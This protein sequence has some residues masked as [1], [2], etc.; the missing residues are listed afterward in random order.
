MP[1]I[2]RV[3]MFGSA[4]RY[5]IANHPDISDFDPQMDTSHL[6]SFDANNLYGHSL[7]QF[8]PVSDF[9]WLTRDEIDALDISTH[10]KRDPLGYYLEVDLTY[11]QTLHDLHNDFPLAPEKI[12]L[13]T[14]GL[15]P[16]TIGLMEKLK[17]K[18]ICT[19]LMSTLTDKRRYILHYE[20]LKL[21]LCLGLQ[22]TCIHRCI[23]FRQKDFIK[24]YIA[25][26][27]RS[28]KEA[29]N[30]FEVFQFKL[31]NNSIY[32]RC[33]YNIFRQVNV[34]LVSDQKKFQRLA[35][36]PTFA[37]TFS[38]NERLVNL[39]M[40]PAVIVCNKPVFIGTSV[41]D[42]SKCHMY[43]F[44]YDHLMTMYSNRGLRL[45][46]TDTDSFHIQIMNCPDVYRDILKYEQFF[47]CS[48]YP[49][50]HFLHSTWHKRVLGLMKMR[51]QGML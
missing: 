51:M 43:S 21:Y 47:D 39:C 35:A 46:Y 1:T 40:K 36:K 45:L 50:N 38:I 30:P 17:L 16:F 44:Y 49:T 5:A 14:E 18:R 7:S 2:I 41:L 4:V 48:N 29:R 33:L 23:R 13:C 37:S 19:K 11:P 6:L 9:Q 26:N 27:N 24:E 20:I 42:L 15:S 3:G 34:Q 22:L 12:E 25:L 32:G 28:R 31:Y 10:P 8:L